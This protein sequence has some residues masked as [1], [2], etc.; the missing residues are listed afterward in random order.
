[1][2][3]QSWVQGPR[4]GRAMM[5]N[6]DLIASIRGALGIYALSLGLELFGWGACRWN[7]RPIR[8]AIQW[9]ARLG[10]L[11]IS[12]A[13]LGSLEAQGWQEA[14]SH[15]LSSGMGGAQAAL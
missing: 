7:R 5:E 9:I 14:F 6:I 8:L 10:W 2:K 12:V 13:L 3:I 11:V 1:M 15:G 4:F